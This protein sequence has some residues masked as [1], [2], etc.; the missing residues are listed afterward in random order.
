VIERSEVEETGVEEAAVKENP[1]VATPDVLTDDMVDAWHRDQKE[2]SKSRKT[3]VGKSEPQ[4]PRSEPMRIQLKKSAGAH[5][6][7]ITSGMEVNCFCQRLLLTGREGSVKE[8]WQQMMALPL[9]REGDALFFDA[10]INGKTERICMLS[11]KMFGGQAVRAGI[12]AGFLVDKTFGIR[13]DDMVTM[14]ESRGVD[15]LPGGV[16]WHALSAQDQADLIAQGRS[17]QM[18]H[19]TEIPDRWH[20]LV[21]GKDQMQQPKPMDL[22]P[23][24]L[25]DKIAGMARQVNPASPAGKLMMTPGK[26]LIRKTFLEP[27]KL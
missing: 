21:S 6:D 5:K 22:G 16:E 1:A 24:L 17:D 26:R 25:L 4:K 20:T 13:A 10:I 12:N 27:S 15:Q 7:L 23:G 11:V 19:L 8:L 14:R 18:R 2:L 9:R 3:P